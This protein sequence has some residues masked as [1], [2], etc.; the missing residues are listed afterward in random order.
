MDGIACS[1]QA[2]PETADFLDQQDPARVAVADFGLAIASIL[3]YIG[4]YLALL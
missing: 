4:H 2:R 3:L 1:M